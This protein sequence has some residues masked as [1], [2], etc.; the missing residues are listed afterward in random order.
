MIGESLLVT[1][2]A[3]PIEEP[4][5]QVGKVRVLTASVIGSVIEWYDYALYG[6]AAA[7]IFGHLFFP[8]ADPMVA[9]VATFGTFAAGFIARPFGGLIAGYYGDK[10]GRKSTLVLTLMTMSLSTTLIGCLPT[11][12]QA[13]ALAPILLLLL[14]ILQG[15]AVGGEWGGAVLMAVEFAPVGRRGLWGSFPQVGPSAGILLGTASFSLVSLFV[16][17]ADFLIWGWRIPFLISLLLAA[18]G[19]YIRLRVSETPSF[20]RIHQLTRQTKNPLMSVV[21]EHPRELFHAIFARFADGGNFYLLTVFLLA[22]AADQAHIPRSQSLI[23]LMIGT[24]ANVITI[25]FF[26]RLSDSLGRRTVFIGGAIFMAVW[27]WPMFAMV[28]S[29]KASMLALGLSIMMIFGHAPVYSTLASYYA[30]LFPARMRYSGISIGY[31]S[32]GI[33]LGGFMPLIASALILT[34]DG[35]P[36]PVILIIAAQSLIAALSLYLGPETYKRDIS[37]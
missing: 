34:T 9:T 6:T 12:A 5:A 20:K 37:M 22:Y 19:M 15:M 36:W 11:Y 28:D 32:A 27:A 4:S 8:K 35:K 24:F 18:V 14:R 26:G 10:I 16:S 13:G 17:E 3:L 1:P 30:E 29:G 21:R 31:Q 7:L 23:C 2:E 25:P 33:I